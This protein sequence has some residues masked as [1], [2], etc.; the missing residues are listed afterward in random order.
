MGVSVQDQTH[1]NLEAISRQKL[2][3][4]GWKVLPEITYHEVSGGQSDAAWRAT[5]WAGLDSPEVH[6]GLHTRQY[7]LR[8]RRRGSLRSKVGT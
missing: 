1:G 4:A 8:S 2:A 7:V 6:C 3:E 5:L